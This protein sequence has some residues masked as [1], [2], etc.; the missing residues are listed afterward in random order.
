M[1]Y[2]LNNIYIYYKN[3]AKKYFNC[4]SY[5]RLENARTNNNKPFKN[6]KNI[7]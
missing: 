2:H 1:K 4:N 5:D 7:K 3:D 6:G